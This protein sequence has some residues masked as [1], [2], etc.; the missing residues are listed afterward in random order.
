M[1]E[2]ARQ[3]EMKLGAMH[4]QATQQG[5]ATQSEAELRTHTRGARQA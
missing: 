5:Y 1:D 2:K 4:K 3:P